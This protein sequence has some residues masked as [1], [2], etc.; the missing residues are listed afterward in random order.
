[1][2]PEGLCGQLHVKNPFEAYGCHTGL[3]KLVGC[4]DINFPGCEG[5]P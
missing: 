3:P 4:V 1:M 2:K 5:I